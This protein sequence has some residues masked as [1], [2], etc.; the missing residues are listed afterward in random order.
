[1]PYAG[2]HD[3]HKRRRRVVKDA[4]NFASH[5]K[6]G[7]AVVYHDRCHDRLDWA[8]GGFHDAHPRL[9]PADWI[10]VEFGTNGQKLSVDLALVE[11]YEL[12]DVV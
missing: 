8:T 4:R 5:S 6:Q 2:I 11:T 12:E 10:V 1:M 7:R 3:E 9:I